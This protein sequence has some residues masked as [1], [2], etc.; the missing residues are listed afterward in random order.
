MILL[1]MIS[2]GNMSL[3]KV[4]HQQASRYLSVKRD[5]QVMKARGLYDDTRGRMSA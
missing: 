2:I 1:R 5:L 4:R 3:I